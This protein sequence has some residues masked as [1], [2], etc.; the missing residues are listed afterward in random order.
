MSFE[1]PVQLVG[2]MTFKPEGGNLINQLYVLNADD[3]S[4]MYKGY[5]PAKM[6]CDEVVFQQIPKDSSSYP[7]IATLIVTNKTQGGKTVQHATGI[8][9]T[10][11]KAAVK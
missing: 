7:M 10:A 1:M 2:G 6:N 5:V 8:K 4:T 9:L 11:P 3:A